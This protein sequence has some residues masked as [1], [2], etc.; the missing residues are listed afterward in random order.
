MVTVYIPR[1]AARW[2]AYPLLAIV[3]ASLVASVLLHR[4]AVTLG[5][6]V[7][8]VTLALVITVLPYF[9]LGRPSDLALYMMTAGAGLLVVV[10]VAALF[11]GKL[12]IVALTLLSVGNLAVIAALSDVPEIET[13]VPF[14][15]LTLVVGGGLAYLFTMLFR[16]ALA[17]VVA[18]ARRSAELQEQLFHA[19]KMEAVGRLAGG[20]AHD[21]NNVLTAIQ[22]RVEL[23]RL[24]D[25]S[26]DVAS[27]LDSMGLDIERAANLVRQIMLFSRREPQAAESFDA[28]DTLESIREMLTR[29]LGSGILLSISGT[30][31]PLTVL[32]NRGQVEQVITNLVVNARDAMPSGGRIDIT[33]DMVLVGQ[34]VHP[35]HTPLKPGPYV[36]LSVRD[37]GVGM[38]E[39]VRSRLFEPFFTT[40]PAGKGT[41]LGLSTAHGIVSQCGGGI[42]V[43]S[44]PGRGSTFAVYLPCVGGAHDPRVPAESD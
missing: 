5:A 12:L 32:A 33:G 3:I 1:L 21:F 43:S 23:L 36:V 24:K 22:S 17:R 35:T 2:I 38:D 26:A 31:R 29:L 30:Q 28:R 19:L 13:A 18:G 10:L 7:L 42:G 34:E 20:I 11:V 25:T 27:A 37:T 44:E 16:S 39:G 6:T 14:A 15:A 41:G 8:A 9:L 40:K 4:G